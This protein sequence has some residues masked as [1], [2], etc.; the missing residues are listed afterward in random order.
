MRKTIRPFVLHT[1]REWTIETLHLKLQNFKKPHPRLWP[2]LTL[3]LALSV[4]HPAFFTFT[5][6]PAGSALKHISCVHDWRRADRK[7]D[8]QTDRKDGK[9]DK[10]I[11]ISPPV[12]ASI[13]D[14]LKAEKDRPTLRCER[15]TNCMPYHLNQVWHAFQRKFMKPTSS[16]WQ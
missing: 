10:Q 7:I 1:K 13:C 16:H 2:S 12:T 4:L 9:T 11:R 14:L 8:K 15:E 6:S 5:L 3:T